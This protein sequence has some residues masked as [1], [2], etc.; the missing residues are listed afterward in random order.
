M[1]LRFL[2]D[3]A[4]PATAYLIDPK[5]LLAV[6]EDRVAMQSRCAALASESAT[7]PDPAVAAAKASLAGSLCLI[8]GRSEDAR[9]YCE[10]A[11]ARQDGTAQ[12]RARVVTEIRLA[13]ALLRLGHG[14]DSVNL[15]TGIAERC[16]QE[17][18]LSSMLHFAL[19]HLG[20]AFW[21][22]GRSDHARVA[23]L[24][25]LALRREIGDQDLIESTEMALRQLADSRIGHPKGSDLQT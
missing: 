18:E 7:E 10:F 3:A 12:S 20:K 9:R 2:A 17:S 15:L 8:L 25:A 4:D 14:D 16:R 24:E 1:N 5:T 22:T 23:F 21:E 19:Q 11:L 13:Q 6:P